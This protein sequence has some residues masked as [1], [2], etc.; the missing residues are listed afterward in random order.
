MQQQDLSLSHTAW[1]RMRLTIKA[2][3]AQPITTTRDN[4]ME[5]KATTTV[6]A[7]YKKDHQGRLVPENLIKP[8]DRARDELVTEI[9]AAA[10]PQRDM[11]VQ[12]KKKVLG[13][14][15]AF[16]ELSAEQYGAKIGGK[17]GNIILLSFDGRYKVQ[18]RNQD[19][20]T[21][22]ERIEAA[23]ELID[24][25]LNRWTENSRPE[26]KALVERAFRT[27]RKGQLRTAE[28]LGLKDLDIDDEEWHRAMEALMDSITVAGSTSYINLYERIGDSDQWRHISLDLAAV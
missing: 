28:V 3:K 13:D 19:H 14:I 16:V 9:I 23:K 7:G 4:P 8:I 18:L 10:L 6:P 2:E 25:C 24:N 12:F 21:F 20:I 15:R 22:D 11:L 5:E 17:K 27:N 1:R 26:I